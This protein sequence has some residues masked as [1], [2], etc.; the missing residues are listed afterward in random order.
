MNT[1][2]GPDIRALR[3]ARKL[4]LV[5]ASGKLGRSPAWL[6]LIERGVTTPSIDDLARIAD[7]YGIKLSYF[8]RSATR[9]PAEQ[10]QVLR[11][12]DRIPIGSAETG[13]VEELLSPRLDGRFEIIK[14]TFAP[15]AESAG[16]KGG[17]EREDGGLILSGRLQLTLEETHFDLSAGD[18]F[19]FQ[20]AR[21]AW[22]NPGPEPAVVIWVIAPVVY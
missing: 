8:F 6:S 7:L 15:G 21:Y 11:A 22:R 10:G 9:S 4:T 20:G 14:S 5:L 19:Q 16:Q 2:I 3:K 12:A 1:Q 17:G 13:L 18:S